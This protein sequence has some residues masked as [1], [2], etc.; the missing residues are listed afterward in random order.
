[1]SKDARK[2]LAV[3]LTRPLVDSWW[4]VVAGVCL[5]LTAALVALRYTLPPPQGPGEIQVAAL[6]LV[7][8]L[9]LFV[10]PP[11]VRAAVNPVISNELTVR[12]LTGVPVLAGIPRVETRDT[13]AAARRRTTL[14]LVLSVMSV[15]VLAAVV[16]FEWVLAA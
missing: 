12:G 5:G 4:T 11:V 14:N 8:G 1:M 15:S 6:G 3:E 13:R 10:G 16:L 7:V 9:M 2:A